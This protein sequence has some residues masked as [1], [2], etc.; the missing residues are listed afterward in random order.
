MIVLENEY[1]KVYLL[2]RGATIYKLETKDRNGNFSN[3][4]LTHEDINLYENGNPGY[5]GATCGRVIGRIKDSKFEIDGKVYELEKNPNGKAICHGGEDNLSG[6]DWDYKVSEFDGKKVCTF[7]ISSPDLENGFPA[8]VDIKVEYVLEKNVLD[9]RYYANAD[10]KTYLN[11]SNHSY[12]NLSNS[13]NIYKHKL[14]LDVDKAVVVDD[15]IFAKEVIDVTGTVF[16]FREEKEIDILE[17][18][19]EIIKTGN[20]LDNPFILNKKN[21]EFD[22]KLKD[23]VSGRVLK[24]KTSYPTIVLYSY[25]YPGV[26]TLLGRNNVKNAGLA[27]ESQFAPNA[28]NDERFYIPIVDKD[29]AY[30]QNI[31]YTFECE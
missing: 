4:V 27:I 19:D 18:L 9:V 11:L 24:V 23:E 12:F 15:N 5:F 13:D 8:N 16:D 26:K 25:N 6:K 30:C 31:K 28:M 1:V 14:T 2:K 3:I 7:E 10:K 22:L 29:N 20:G 21:E 17:N